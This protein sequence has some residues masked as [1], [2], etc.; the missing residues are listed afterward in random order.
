MVSLMR[1][2][3]RGDDSLV[4]YYI[5]CIFIFLKYISNALESLLFPKNLT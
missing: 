3:Y 2:G 5:I 4:I 1:E